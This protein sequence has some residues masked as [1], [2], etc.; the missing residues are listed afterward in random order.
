MMRFLSRDEVREVD[1]RAIEDWG[2]PSV[3]LMENAGRGAADVLMAQQPKGL[4]LIGCG[5]GNNGGDGLVAARHLALRGIAVRVLLFATPDSLSSDCRVNWQ[6]AEHLDL[7]RLVDPQCDA[8]WLS[9]Q[10]REA[11]WFVDGLF[12]TGLAGPLRSPFDRIVEAVNA[13]RK[14][15]VALD[16]PSGLDADT[17]LPLGATIRAERTVTFAAMKKGF[18]NPAS[19]EWIGEIHVADIGVPIWE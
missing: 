1:R 7:P 3:V 11:E 8:A 19:Q 6:I 9:E 15:V 10:I 14:R 13:S 16:L 4:V 12:G 5:K 17:G 18:A 2:V